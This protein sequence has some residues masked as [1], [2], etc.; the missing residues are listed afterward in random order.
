MYHFRFLLENSSGLYFLRGCRGAHPLRWAHR[1]AGRGCVAFFGARFKNVLDILL[2]VLG[3][4]RCFQQRNRE[5][6]SSFPCLVERHPAYSLLPLLDGAAWKVPWLTH[7]LAY[8]AVTC[9]EVAFVRKG[10]GTIRVQSAC[11]KVKAPARTTLALVMGHIR[12]P[13]L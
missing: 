9:I 7:A 13:S 4:G 5:M 1:E 2:D 6:Q 12:V 10:E 3:R 11:G 8:L